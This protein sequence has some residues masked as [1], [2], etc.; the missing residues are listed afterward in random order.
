M[1]LGLHDESKKLGSALNAHSVVPIQLGPTGPQVPLANAGHNQHRSRNVRRVWPVAPNLGIGTTAPTTALTI[2]VP[3]GKT[4]ISTFAGAGGQWQ[5]GQNVGPSSNDDTFGLY[6]YTKG[7][8]AIWTATTAGNVGIGIINPGQTL[9]VYGSNTNGFME[10]IYN[11]GGGTTS[12]GLAI[13]AGSNSTAG[14]VMVYLIRPDGTA[15]GSI[16]Q[17]SATTVAYNTTSDRRIK[18]NI[19]DS[20]SGLDLLAKI[21]VRDYNYIADPD[22]QT[23]QGFI[24]QE[25]YDIYPQAVTVGGED[26]KTRPWQVDYGKLTPLLVKSVQDLQS[27]ND[28]L[29][30]RADKAEADSK[31]KDDAITQLK[32]ESAQLK[33]FLCGQFPNAPMCQP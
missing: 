13:S 10:G 29:K 2:A 26:P 31:A 23:Q 4:P 5:L 14:A 11:T 28:Q 18:E 19:A 17:N 33:G 22:K 20:A 8:T 15:I 7:G 6:S 3:T 12:D 9:S 16:T 25:L 1:S 21:K 32:A 30:A 24:A 27:E